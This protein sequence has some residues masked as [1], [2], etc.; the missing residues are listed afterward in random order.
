MANLWTMSRCRIFSPLY[1]IVMCDI[2]NF[3]VKKIMCLNSFDW[4]HEKWINSIFALYR[5]QILF[6][7]R[8]NGMKMSRSHIYF[9]FYAVSSSAQKCANYWLYLALV[10][11][12]QIEICKPIL[13][14]KWEWPNK[15]KFGAWGIPCSSS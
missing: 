7:F 14:F 3:K 13:L 9:N 6:F 2:I 15:N 8:I 1:C 12:K 10:K 11:Q 5:L 4:H